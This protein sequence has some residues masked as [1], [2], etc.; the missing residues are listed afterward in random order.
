MKLVVIVMA[1]S[2][3]L[4]FGQDQVDFKPAPSDILDAQFPKVDSNSRLQ[5][6]LKAPDA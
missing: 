6:R 3:A 5:I 2:A 1:L 4:C